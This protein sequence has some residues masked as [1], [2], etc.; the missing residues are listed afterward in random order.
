MQFTGGR[1]RKTGAIL[2]SGVAIVL[3]LTAWG[4]EGR[5]ARTPLSSSSYL[6]S[7]VACSSPFM[8]RGSS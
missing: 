6:T 2:I 5:S 8:S 4:A 1:M 7:S 3:L